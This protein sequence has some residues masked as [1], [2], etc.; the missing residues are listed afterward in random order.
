MFFCHT[1][2]T[3][4]SIFA[5]SLVSAMHTVLRRKSSGYGCCVH[6]NHHQQ[7][8]L[9]VTLFFLSDILAAAHSLAAPASSLNDLGTHA[10]AD[11]PT[12]TL[13]LTPYAIPNTT[14]RARLIPLERAMHCNGLG[15]ML[16]YTAV[17]YDHQEGVAGRT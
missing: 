17:Q 14:L 8:I 12:S 7:P 4:F 5:N 11:G 2:S 9:V 6:H 1:C 16:H 13:Q 3:C 15:A 10:L